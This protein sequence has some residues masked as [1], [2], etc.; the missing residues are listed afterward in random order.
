M[1][2]IAVTVLLALIVMR[3]PWGIALVAT[4]VV[5][6]IA[7]KTF[8]LISSKRIP[9]AIGPETMV[10]RTVEVVAPCRPCGAVRLR[11][12]RWNARCRDGA[13]VGDTVIVEAVQRLTL[14][15]S[16]TARTQPRER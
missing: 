4:A 15:V 6:E 2:A 11:S 10:G 14:I 7:E 1:V 5:W 8:W 13:D 16:S 3:A 12:E 9:L